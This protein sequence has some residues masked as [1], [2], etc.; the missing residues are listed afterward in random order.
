MG[1]VDGAQGSWRDVF[2]QGHAVVDGAAD[3]GVEG[4]VVIQILGAAIRHAVAIEVYPVELVTV[5]IYSPERI[6][7][8]FTPYRRQLPNTGVTWIRRRS[9]SI[10]GQTGTEALQGQGQVI[11][12]FPGD[13]G[14]VLTP[15]IVRPSTSS[16]FTRSI[17]IDGLGF[18]GS[19]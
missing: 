17:W 18:I 7:R 15:A 1:L 10:L 8:N 12:V 11:A 2:V 14:V 13:I 4:A 6:T 19:G 5:G 3:D 9:E 16:R